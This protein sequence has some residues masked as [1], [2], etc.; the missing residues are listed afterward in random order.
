MAGEFE[1]FKMFG[2]IFLKGGDTTLKNIENIDKKASGADKTFTKMGSTVMNWGKQ[3]LAATGIILSVKGITG[4]ISKFVE[5]GDTLVDTSRKTG[6]SIKSLQELKWVAGQT[7]ASFETVTSA[8]ARL[9]MAMYDANGAMNEQSEAFELLGVDIHTA[10]GAYKS[11]DDFLPEVLKALSNMGNETERDAVAM[12]LLGRSAQELAPLMMDGENS[13]EALTKKFNALG[14]AIDEDVIRAADSLADDMATLKQAFTVMESQIMQELLPALTDLVNYMIENKDAF[15]NFIGGGIDAIKT[16][17]GWIQTATDNVYRFFNPTGAADAKLARDFED[18]QERMISGMKATTQAEID[19]L[20]TKLDARTASKDKFMNLLDEQYQEELDKAADIEKALR[21]SINDQLDD[22]S[23]A[24]DDKMDMIDEEH[25]AAIEAI[26]DERDAKIKALRGQSDAI[27]EQNRNE[28]IAGL[29]EKIA[30]TKSVK[31]R[32]EY[33][34]QLDELLDEAAKEEIE[35]Q[36]ETINEDADNKKEGLDEEYKNKKKTEEDKYE[37]AK[38]SLEN[39]LDELDNFQEEYKKKLDKELEAKKKHENEMFLATTQKLRDELAAIE[40]FAKDQND[41]LSQYGN[42]DVTATL[43]KSYKVRI[44]AL[45][46]LLK[47]E[48]PAGL[49]NQY[50]NELDELEIALRLLQQYSGTSIVGDTEAKSGGGGAG[51]ASGTDFVPRS[52]VYDVGEYGP[53]RVFLPRGA[54]VASNSDLK[55]QTINVYVTG[56]HILG[57]DDGRKLADLIYR[58]WQMAGVGKA[59]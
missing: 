38:D 35:K 10:T 41:I 43:M 20:Q 22:L 29:K 19:T 13:V 11:I 15:S 8:T 5:L 45:T 28:E 52:D 54:A 30:R 31:N 23:D 12:K 32:R 17:V 49:K 21:K 36:I 2:S 47:T 46:D 57:M 16:L 39:Q 33:Q 27:D 37:A 9:K 26:D 1:L 58:R 4:A 56:N 50:Q 53:E 18:L 7:G 25:D 55:G 14:L 34:K 6:L 59:R 51:W 3:I 24:H 48:L 42:E 40:Q 44:G